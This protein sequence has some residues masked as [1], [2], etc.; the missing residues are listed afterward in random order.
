MLMYHAAVALDL[1]EQRKSF[2]FEI[3]K[4]SFLDAK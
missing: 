2:I 3:H 4:F 1:G